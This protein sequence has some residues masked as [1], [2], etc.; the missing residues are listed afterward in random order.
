MKNKPT[1]VY[2]NPDCFTQVD[3]TVLCHLTK[4]F[5]VVWFYLYESLRSKDMRYSPKMAQEYADKYGI[6]LEVVDP[7]SRLRSPRTILFYYRL[8]Q[9]INRYKPDIVYGCITFPFWTYCYHFIKCK[10]KV[11]GVHD[12]TTHSKKSTLSR[13]WGQFIKERWLKRF[14]HIFTFS[15]NQHS[16]LKEELGKESTMV[17]MSYKSFGR[18]EQAPTALDN[19]VHL[20]FFGS[21]IRYK[22]LDLLIEALE[23]LRKDG[24]KNLSLTVAGKGEAW[25]ECELL[26]KTPEMFNLHVR[27]IDNK[28]IPDLMCSH[29]FL[30]LPYR[31]ATQSGPLVTALAYGT[32]V[33]APSYG[34]FTDTFDEK[35]AILFKP[36]ELKQALA[37]ISSM[38]EKEYTELRS[39]VEE[40]RRHYSEE[41]IAKNYS[42]AFQQIMSNE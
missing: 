27:F 22:G 9:K 17:G 29:H 39:N 5:N 24:V 6:T 4:D 35:S 42:T 40:V 31:D 26:I 38:N 11:L 20:L 3:D 36:G 28:E 30:V 32:P 34:C 23:E 7:Q 2:F 12:V 33:I 25:R 8:A 15:P 18:S 1:L 37:R 14:E 41:N 13:L 21:I 16:L 19:G 10:N